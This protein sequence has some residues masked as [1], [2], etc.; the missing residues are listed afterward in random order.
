MCCAF[1]IVLASDPDEPANIEI[2]S[3]IEKEIQ[4]TT[5][6][7]KITVD[8]KADLDQMLLHFRKY[9]KEILK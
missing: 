6:N 9:L 2:A 4:D 3:E 5:S 1:L 8:E 7:S